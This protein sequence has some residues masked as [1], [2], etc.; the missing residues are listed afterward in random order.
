MN[1]PQLLTLWLGRRSYAV[2]DFCD[3][4]IQQWSTLPKRTQD[5]I[6]KEL[7]KAIKRDSEDRDAGSAFRHLGDDCDLAEWL[8]VQQVINQ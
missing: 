7:N 4:L 5:L 6:S 1:D 2:S 8:R 3:L